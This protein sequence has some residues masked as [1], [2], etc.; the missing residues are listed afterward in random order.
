MASQSKQVLCSWAA[1]LIKT[2][3]DY[4]PIESSVSMGDIVYVPDIFTKKSSQSIVKGI[5]KVITISNNN[6]SFKLLSNKIIQRRIS[7]L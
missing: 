3:S 2:I 5:G 6:Y 4:Q 1:N 7:Q